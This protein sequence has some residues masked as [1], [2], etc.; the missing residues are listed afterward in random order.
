L[1]PIE[2]KRIGRALT[3]NNAERAFEFE[4]SGFVLTGQ[5]AKSEK[6]A[7][8]TLEVDVLINGQLLETV[9]MP[10]SWLTRRLE[11]AWNYDL[12]EGKH[13]LTL[14]ARNIPE[15]YRI[16]PGELITYSRKKPYSRI[17]F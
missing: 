2:R 4:G 1:Y 17:Y 5:A 6:M 15:G 13:T 12:P 7:D 14:K 11:I 3:N 9:K 16:E 8:M 10:T